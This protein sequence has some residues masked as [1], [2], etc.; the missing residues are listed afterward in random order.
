MKRRMYSAALMALNAMSGIAAAQTADWTGFYLGLNGGALGNS[1]CENWAKLTPGIG[2][3]LFIANC[4]DNSV[5]LFGGQ[6]GFNWQVDQVVLGLEGDWDGVGSKTSNRI[7]NYP[8]DDEFGSPVPA[9]TFNFTAKSIPNGL[10]TIRG[11]V[12]YAVGNWLPYFTAG[13]AFAGGSGRSSA[14]FTPIGSPSATALFAG[15]RTYSSNGW[16]VGAGVEYQIASAWSVKAEY[17]YVK[18]GS[19]ANQVTNCSGSAATCDAL[20]NTIDLQ[21]TTNSVTQNVFRVGFNYRFGSHRAVSVVA[22]AVP[23]ASTR[24]P[25]GPN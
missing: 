5:Y 3:T 18:L 14:T 21:S 19:G 20:V 6:L 24:R 15:G 9:G 10:G 23:V 12:G 1:T 11:R 13:A 4:P 2:R 25:P 8:G 16:T 7:Y 22:A 17:L